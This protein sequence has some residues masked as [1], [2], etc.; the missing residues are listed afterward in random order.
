VDAA[1]RAKVELPGVGKS[2]SPRAGVEPAYALVAKTHPAR[3]F[4]V[5]CDLD[6]STKLAKAAAAI[7]PGNNYQ[8][9]IEEQVSA[10][11]A[12]GIAMASHE[13][14]AVVFATFSAFFEGIAREGLEMWRYTRNLNGVNEGLNAIM[15]LSHVGACTGRDHFSGWSLDWIT[16]AMGYLPYLDRFYTPA[17]ARSAF[18]ACTD[19]CARYG[20]HIVGIPRDNLPIL[21]KDDGS[22]LWNPADAWTPCT[23]LRAKAGA[24]K[25]ILAM[26]ATAFLADAAAKSLPDTDVIVVNGLPFGAGELDGLLKKY[27]RGLVTV[28]DGIIGHRCV[29]LRGFA[30]LVQGAAYGKRVPLA[31]V[32]ITDP[33][34]APSEGH[35]EVW[36]HF[37]LTADAVAEAAKGL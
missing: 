35:H 27:P 32:G 22:P 6:P 36:A 9:S 37:G 17:D 14:L 29:G 33:T 5:S 10:L 23:T 25:A 13:P 2:V 31:H 24:T 4:N 30:S 3:F 34:V 15:H 28:E 7:P 20:A 18:I 11:M 12:N 16:L 26:G 1:V 19:A 21:A 8:M